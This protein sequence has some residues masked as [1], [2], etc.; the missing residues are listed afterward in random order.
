MASRRDFKIYQPTLAAVALLAAAVGELSGCSDGGSE[1]EDSTNHRAEPPPEGAPGCSNR[2]DCDALANDS[3]TSSQTTGSGAAT[4]ECAYQPS[5]SPIEA[6]AED[7]E[8]L[9]A[10]GILEQQVD[11]NTEFAPFCTGSLIGRNKVLTACHC[12]KESIDNS[13]AVWFRRGSDRIKIVDHDPLCDPSLGQGGFNNVGSDVAVMFLEE[14]ADEPAVSIEVRNLVK[15]DI[16]LG[17]SLSAAGYFFQR[18][19]NTQ[20]GAG[21]QVA[22]FTLR[23]LAGPFLKNAFGT[24]DNFNNCAKIWR[25]DTPI[26][27]RS[28]AEALVFDRTHWTIGPDGGETYEMDM[29]DVFEMSLLEDYQAWFD[30]GVDGAQPCK[31]DSGS[32]LVSQTDEGFAVYGVVSGSINLDASEP[33]CAFGAVYAIFT[34]ETLTWLQGLRAPQQ[35]PDIDPPRKVPS[36][37]VW[38]AA[39]DVRAGRVLTTAGAPWQP[40]SAGLRCARHGPNGVGNQLLAT[41]RDLRHAGCCGTLT[42]WQRGVHRR[43]GTRGR[44]LDLFTSRS[45]RICVES[46]QAR[47][48]Y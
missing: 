15:D 3:T 16:E 7:G 23:A 14:D 44:L 17:E 1:I 20:V 25:D 32:P 41:G 39:T 19:R 34:E 6:D 21:G 4:G 28:Q 47:P 10:V 38:T 8:V 31:G 26:G 46:D 42:M 24:P 33:R 48:G 27:S 43:D 11:G 18:N 29:D 37:G 35:S 36:P 9:S 5:P 30:G 12:A 40:R 22:K 2:L 13:K 45:D